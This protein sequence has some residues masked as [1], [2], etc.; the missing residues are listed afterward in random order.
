MLRQVAEKEAGKT[1]TKTQLAKIKLLERKA[2]PHTH[3]H[4][5]IYIYVHIFV[6]VRGKSNACANIAHTPRKLFKT[7]WQLISPARCWLGKCPDVHNVYVFVCLCV[8]VAESSDEV[9][10]RFIQQQRQQVW[11]PKLFEVESSH[12]QVPPEAATTASC[13]CLPVCVLVCVCVW[14]RER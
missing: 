8:G 14:K 6:C 1:T 11:V 13:E 3:T 9:K 2:N 10:Q 5:H 4:K 7:A 12:S